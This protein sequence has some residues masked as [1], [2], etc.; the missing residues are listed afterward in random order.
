MGKYSEDQLIA[1]AVS[2]IGDDEQV[3]AAGVFGLAE[4]LVAATAGTVA[5]GVVGDVAAGSDGNVA[6]AVL[7]GIAAKK[8][9][10]ESQGATVKLLVA[11]TEQHIHI[12]N[13]DT[14]G[15]LPDVLATFVR[16]HAEVSITKMGLSRTIHLQDTV[17]GASLSLTG[18]LLPI[19]PLAKGDKLV[20]DL[21]AD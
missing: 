14:D 21:L 16:A 10:A 12:L 15:R 3:L 8:A 4:L 19:S 18:G 7:G 17:S 6:G 11:V 2:V 13:Q 9:Y 1:Q 5:G 20:L